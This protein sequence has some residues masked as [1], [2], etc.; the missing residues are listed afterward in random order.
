MVSC[1]L[2][3]AG[4][5]Q[6]FGSPK[7]LAKINN[8]PVIT[9]I[10]QVLLTTIIDEIIVVL[11]AHAQLIE[12]HIL[13]HTRVRVVYNKDYEKGQTTSVQCALNAT[14]KTSE[15]FLIWP[16]DCP[17]IQSKTVSALIAAQC[18]SQSIVIPTYQSRRGHPP[19][20]DHQLKDRI[21]NLSNTEG[22]N[23]LMKDPAINT[24][25]LALDD[26]GIVQTFNTPEEFNRIIQK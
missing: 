8:T 11:G 21:L 24:I 22:L 26:P 12:P 14:A 10:Q 17:V 2:L 20:F 7:A 18:P 4:L 23:M 9:H 6:R 25:E 13:N 3:S 19:V 5:S 16:V 1:L 15:R